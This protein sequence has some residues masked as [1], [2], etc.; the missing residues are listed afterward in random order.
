MKA[1]PAMARFATCSTAIEPKAVSGEDGS[2]CREGTEFADPYLSFD[3]T[4]YSYRLVER[5]LSPPSGNMA[6][7]DLWLPSFAAFFKAT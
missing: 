6:T 7:T 2:R 4:F 5:Y 1:V 3:L